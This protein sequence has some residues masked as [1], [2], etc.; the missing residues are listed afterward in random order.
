MEYRSLKT[1]NMSTTTE[2]IVFSENDAALNE[3]SEMLVDVEKKMS[4]YLTNSE[5]NQINLKAGKEAVKVSDDVFKVICRS[6]K[7]SE[8]TKGSFDIAL[9][10]V[11]KEWGI[12]SDNEH[13]PPNEKINELKKHAE[14]KNIIADKKDNKIKLKYSDMKI[15][16]GGIA[17]GY[18]ADKAVKI[19]KKNNIQSA[20]I[21]IG[22]NVAVLGR[23]TDN[24]LWTVGIQNPFKE[25]GVIVGALQCENTCVVTSGNYVRYLKK[26]NKEYGH[27]INPN[28]GQTIDNNIASITVVCKNCTQA[29]ALSTALFV[30]SD[31]VEIT[32]FIKKMGDCSVIIIAKNKNIY[33]SS[34][35]AEKFY[36]DEYC[37]Y[38]VE[39]I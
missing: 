23:K 37:D 30:M 2:Q 5:I 38:N 9:G 35:I 13:I 8:L 10:S 24:S 4:F 29:D 31:K 11:I 26:N 32:E 34:N 18:A 20:M 17:K 15:D 16:L 28:D 3:V 7:Y 12:F 22:G 36:L 19:Y 39:I 1:L 6:I 21:N 25:R 14:Y 27:I 33:L